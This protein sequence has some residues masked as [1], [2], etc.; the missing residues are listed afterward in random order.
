MAKNKKKIIY[1]E[2]YAIGTLISKEDV[3]ANANKATEF[4]VANIGK[5]ENGTEFIT[6]KIII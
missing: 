5:M 2:N 4:H 6:I 1:Q 3:I